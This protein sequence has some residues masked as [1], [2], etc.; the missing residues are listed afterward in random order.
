VTDTTHSKSGF[1]VCDAVAGT[2]NVLTPMVQGLA[3][4]ATRG[5]V[6][7][8]LRDVRGRYAER[9]VLAENVR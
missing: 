6:A 7:H 1:H 2:A 4:Q 8:T 3:L 5:E 9:V